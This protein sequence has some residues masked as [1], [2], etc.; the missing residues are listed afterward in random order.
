MPT[1]PPLALADL[2][3]YP[4]IAIIGCPGA[5]KSTLA[6]R[7]AAETGH[8]LIHLDYENWQPGWLPIPKEEWRAKQLEWVNGER[9]IIDG[10]Y[11][12]TLELRYAAADLVIFLDIPRAVCLW[13]ILRREGRPRADLR[14]GVEAPGIFSK[15]FLSMLGF[16]WL[17]N[18]KSRP[19]VTALRAQYPGTAFW[20]IRSRGE[21]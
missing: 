9:W 15:S 19:K 13:S 21:F 7:I 16:V 14:P 17:Y 4:R 1:I 10:N 6:R 8:P 12:A 18:K 2:R 3:A 5:G 20:R 11:Q